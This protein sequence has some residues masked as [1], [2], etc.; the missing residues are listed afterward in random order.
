MS[1][2]TTTLVFQYIEGSDD[3][4]EEH[5]DSYCDDEFIVCPKCNNKCDVNGTQDGYW[6]VD[7]YVQCGCGDCEQHDEPLSPVLAIVL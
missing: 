5:E 7:G 1:K 6:D 4:F 3:S 2:P